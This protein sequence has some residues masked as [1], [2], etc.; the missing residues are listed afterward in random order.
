LYRASHHSVLLEGELTRRNVPYVKYG[1][2]KFLESAHIKDL[3]SFLRL[4]ENPRDLV[5]GSR[6][7][8]LV[9]G[10]GPKRARTLMD[11]MIQSGG[12]TDAWS[13]TKVTGAAKEI[14]PAFQKL[15]GRL[16][17]S[18]PLEL[19]SQI[20]LVRRFYEPMLEL[21]YDN[22]GPRKRDL[23]QLEQLSVRFSDRQT[24]LTEMTLDP[25]EGTE[26]LAGP[27][28]LDE[29]YLILSTIHSAKGLEWDTVYVIHAADGNI[30]SDM[31]TGSAAEIEEELRLFYVA[32]TRARDQL[33]VCH[34]LRYY[35]ANRHAF[36]DRHGYAQRTRFIPPKLT[37]YFEPC[38]PDEPL[39]GRPDEQTGDPTAT[40]RRIRGQIQSLFS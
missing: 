15:M 18:E 10:I 36:S 30:P 26:D 33:H 28:L 27:P 5:A 13:R 14:W 1:G 11:M 6:V 4:A 7:L 17:R 24:M 16:M 32:L 37:K 2:L 31:A 34:P 38:V 23:E 9:P 3:M 12:K 25:P 22:A 20:E 29:D 39:D 8:Q 21:K 19:S 40:P 35:H